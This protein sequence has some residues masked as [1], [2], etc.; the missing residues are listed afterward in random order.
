MRSATAVAGLL[1]LGLHI[2][3]VISNHDIVSG[4]CIQCVARIIMSSL[5]YGGAAR[6][7][8]PMFSCTQ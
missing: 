6:T 8:M 4:M 2:T 1:L 5:L 3:A 7:Y